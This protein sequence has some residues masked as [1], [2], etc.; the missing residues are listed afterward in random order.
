ML[1]IF[2]TPKPFRGSSDIIQRNALHSWRLLHSDVEVIL[3]GGEEGAAQV[4]AELG[5]RHEP[6]VERSERGPKYLNYMFHRAQEIAQHEFLCYAN[7]NIA[8]MPEFWRAFQRVAAWRE[9]SL[10]AGQRWDADVTQ[11]LEFECADWQEQL[12]RF[13]S[14]VPVPGFAMAHE[15]HSRKGLRR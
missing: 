13:A 7:C 5:L 12:R 11:R 8:L 1:T 3:F 14:R 6:H 10:M 15:E 2:S 4:Y 9:A